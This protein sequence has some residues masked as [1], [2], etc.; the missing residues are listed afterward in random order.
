MQRILGDGGCNESAAAVHQGNTD[1]QSAEIYSRNNRHFLPLVK[2]TVHLPA[3]IPRG[4]LVDR[5]SHLREI[6]GYVMLEAVLA[7]VTQKPLQVR[8]LDDSSPAESVERIVGERALAGIA[9]HDAG[10]VI[11]REAGKTHRARLHAAHAGPKGILFPDSAGNDFLEIHAHVLKEVLGQVAAV[12][13]DR[14]VGIVSVVVVP[15]EYR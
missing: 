7:D 2:V 14:L 15:I 5:A 1:V 3:E 9:A 8:N 10:R 11:G 4:C 13:A 6:R 12:K